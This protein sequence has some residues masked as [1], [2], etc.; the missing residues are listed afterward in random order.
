MHVRPVTCGHSDFYLYVRH[1]L[2][3]S[4][5]TVSEQY[6][7]N[8]LD[9]NTFNKT[10]TLPVYRNEKVM[11]QPDQRHLTATEK[12]GELARDEKLSFCSGCNVPTLF[13]STSD[14]LVR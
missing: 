13:E 1:G 2:V 7:S 14:V 9:E 11:D 6:C 3:N 12:N 8:I 5:F 4:C 10:Y